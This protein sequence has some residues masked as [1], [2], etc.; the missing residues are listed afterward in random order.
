MSYIKTDLL[1]DFGAE[2]SPTISPELYQDIQTANKHI[3]RRIKASPKLSFPFDSP[4]PQQHELIESYCDA[5]FK[6][7]PMLIQAPTGLKIAIN[8]K[9]KKQLF[10]FDQ[11]IINQIN[12][13]SL[14]ILNFK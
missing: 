5:T 7:R 12:L 1:P 10:Q 3:N 8:S 11:V 4:R 14:F 6:K 13:R 2:P 9:T